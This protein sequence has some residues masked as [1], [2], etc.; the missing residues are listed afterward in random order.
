MVCAKRTK[1][2]EIILHPMLLLFDEAHLEAHFGLFR[3][4]ANLDAKS[5]H[6]FGRTFRRLIN[7]IGH[8]SWNS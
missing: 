1:G 2:S 7:R 3:D 8:T 5:M 4:N 6:G